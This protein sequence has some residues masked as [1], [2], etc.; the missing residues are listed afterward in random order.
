MKVNMAY[1]KPSLVSANN[2]PFFF[3]AVGVYNSD[4]NLCPFGVK[5]LGLYTSNGIIW[6]NRNGTMSET[7][8]KVPLTKYKYQVLPAG[9]KITL[10]VVSW[11]DP[12]S[13]G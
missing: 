11:E 8:S 5:K 13:E 2:P 12:S 10:E 4:G 3:E 9:S 6:F 7:D 1:E